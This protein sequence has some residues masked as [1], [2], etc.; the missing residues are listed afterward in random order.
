MGA[1]VLARLPDAGDA[2]RG[3]GAA[4]GTLGP[5]ASATDPTRPRAVGTDP[6]APAPRAASRHSREC[7]PRWGTRRAAGRDRPHRPD[8]PRVIADFF[9]SMPAAKWALSLPGAETGTTVPS[10]YAELGDA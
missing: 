1:S 5:R 8:L 7:P 6:A 2:G 4:V 10:L 9:A 3:D